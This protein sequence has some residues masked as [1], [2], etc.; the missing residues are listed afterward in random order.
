MNVTTA[1]TIVLAIAYVFN[2]HAVAQGNDC[3]K[4]ICV[5]PGDE[6]W[7]V[8]AR[9]VCCDATPCTDQLPC[10]AYCGD[11]WLDVA[12]AEVRSSQTITPVVY[13]HGYQTDLCDAKKRGL[14]V[15]Q[16][17]FA[18]R[19]GSAPIRF[20]IWAWK[21]EKEIRRPVRD[22]DLK[23]KR[24]SQMANAFA[25]TIN[26]LGPMPPMVIG[27]SLGAQVIMS[28]LTHSCAYNGPPVQLVLIAAA[29]DCCFASCCGL[30]DS[31]GKVE[32]SAIFYNA[33]DIAIKTSSRICKLKFGCKFKSFEELATANS[34]LGEVN[35]FDITEFASKKHSI[36]R[37]T[38]LPVVQGI[39]QQLLREFESQ[40]H[41]SLSGAEL[42]SDELQPTD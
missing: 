11:K 41:P 6:I 12:F 32:R 39:I 2:A 38:S 28:A 40:V 25:A 26:E 5:L 18:C 17:L 16:N 1:F 34:S 3:E 15:Y 21:S 22:Y 35:I 8:S 33:D 20:V 36:V 19:Q 23:S 13:V 7:L 42:T 31:C 9:G 24:A 29:N 14:Q 27:Y 4:P 30:L 37:Y 10:Q